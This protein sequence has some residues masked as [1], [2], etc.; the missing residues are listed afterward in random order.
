MKKFRLTDVGL[1]EQANKAHQQVID[2]QVSAI[3]A[4][5]RAGDA[6]NAAKKI[7]VR[8]ASN[9][10]G[11]WTPWLE[12][13]FKASVQ[14][15]RVYMRIAKHWPRLERE[16][17]DSTKVRPGGPYPAARVLPKVELGQ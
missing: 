1:A 5:R 17:F 3:H 4:A 8:R 6:L 15:A 7:V 12:A 11:S 9:G 14:T 10:R 16:V 2:S 13:N